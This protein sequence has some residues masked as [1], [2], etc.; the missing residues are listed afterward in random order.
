MKRSQL[1]R[2]YRRVSWGRLFWKGK[3]PSMRRFDSNDVCI[4]LNGVVAIHYKTMEAFIE[5][6]EEAEAQ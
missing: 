1:I 3:N 6:I 5:A 4:V 2:R